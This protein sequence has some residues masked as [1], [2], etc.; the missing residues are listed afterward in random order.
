METGRYTR[1][2]AAL[3]WT[4][5]ALLLVAT[6]LALFRETFAAHAETMITLHKAVG[7]AILALAL[8]RLG[9]RL[10]HRAPSL[11]DAIPRWERRLAG[12]VHFGL[13]GLM[14]AVP[15]AG[16]LFVSMA[17]SSRPIDWR[18]G[19]GVPELPLGTDD[20]AAFVWHEAHELTGFAFIAL[21]ALHL[22]GALRHLL[23]S[24]SGLVDRMAGNAPLM[25]RAVL[26]LLVLWLAGLALDLFGVR[27]VG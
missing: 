1:V 24:R 6:G 2:A 5:A 10:G 7:L 13:Y 9:W 19:E 26:A 17:P 23:V 27:L 15:L 25:A 12:T 3:H 22:V 11:P 14:I 16:W 21:I 20:S 18:G 8:L 4:I